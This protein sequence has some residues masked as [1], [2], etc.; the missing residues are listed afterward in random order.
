MRIEPFLVT[1]SSELYS[2]VYTERERAFAKNTIVYET[3]KLQFASLE[4][5]IKMFKEVVL[6]GG[7]TVNEWRA[8]CN[9]GPIEGGDVRIMRLD[10]AKAD[11]KKEEDDNGDQE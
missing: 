4:K 2:R 11:D 9:M 10:A 1:L 5:K 6:Y 3:N 8:G 7:M